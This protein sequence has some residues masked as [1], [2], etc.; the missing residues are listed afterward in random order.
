[1]GECVCKCKIARV[2]FP[3]KTKD[4]RKTIKLHWKWKIDNLD[5]YEIVVTG[6]VIATS[7]MSHT[8][9]AAINTSAS[10]HFPK[11]NEWKVVVVFF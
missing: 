1:M 4:D 7:Y 11:E 5:F 6:I 10:I 9:N 8:T 3:E 2:H